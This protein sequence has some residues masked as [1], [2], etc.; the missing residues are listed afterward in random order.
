MPQPV[1]MPNVEFTARRM[2]LYPAMDS[3]TEAIKFIEAQVPVQSANE[4][5]SLLMMFQNTLLKELS[6]ANQLRN[7]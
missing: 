4:M 3:V 5:F 2:S 1:E 6:D 7:K